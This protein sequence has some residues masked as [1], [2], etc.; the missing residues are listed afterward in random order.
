MGREIRRVPPNWE[1]PKTIR[2]WGE[3]YQPMYDRD[4]GAAT[5]DW[6]R[7]RFWFRVCRALPTVTAA[8]YR[9]AARQP[10]SYQGVSR[11]IFWN[12][13]DLRGQT[14]T[15][16]EWH[17]DRPDPDYHHPRWGRGEATWYQVYE[18][19]SEG[20]PVTP[21]FATKDELIAYLVEHGTFWDQRRAREG[22]QGS[23]QWSPAAARRFVEGG[24]YAPSLVAAAGRI[25][26]PREALADGG[27]LAGG[28]DG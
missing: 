19:V 26:G 6:K 23:A 12:L 8:L 5:R 14:C 16:E 7:A 18:T 4:I 21:P 1:H 13:H 3:D 24:G 2:N 25:E 27:L 17:G 28:D 22:R 15:F 11:W 10:Y 9:W 20:T